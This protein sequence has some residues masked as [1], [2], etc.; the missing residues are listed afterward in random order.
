L[1]AT[2]LVVALC[3]Q[4]SA[5]ILA[6]LSIFVAIYLGIRKGDSPRRPLIIQWALFIIAVTSL[7]V[8]SSIL[9]SEL[10]YYFGMTGIVLSYVCLTV[11]GWLSLNIQTILEKY[12][13]Y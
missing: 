9:M 10:G 4:L 2:K 6:V 8:Y 5:T 11:S 1:Q 12:R 3:I 13:E 7:H